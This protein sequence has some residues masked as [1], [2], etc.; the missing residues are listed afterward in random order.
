V[1]TLASL[2]LI[3]GAV[4]QVV[5]PAFFPRAPSLFVAA[6]PT[7]NAA[8]IILTFVVVTLGWRWIRR[9][10]VR[11]HRVAMG[12]GVTLFLTFLVLY[13]YR[14]ALEGP[15]VFPKTGLVRTVYYVVLAVHVVLAVV[16]LP[17]LYYVLGLALTR[18]VA[19]L[20]GS[21]HPRVGRVAA[22]LWL[23]SCALGV[24]VYLLLYS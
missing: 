23:V 10:E 16:C 14:V 21:R 18:P 5:P 15:T 22:A 8:L 7:I 3:F 1:A 24:V 19:D 12:A 6:I 2:A 17:L 13:L 4:L 20:R 9:D 11:K